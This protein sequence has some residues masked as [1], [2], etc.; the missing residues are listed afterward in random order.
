MTSFLGQLAQMGPQVSQMGTQ[1]G[2]G[3]GRVLSLMQQLVQLNA[4]ATGYDVKAGSTT[5]RYTDNR[6]TFNSTARSIDLTIEAADAVVQLSY[7]GVA[8]APEFYVKAGVIYSLGIACKAMQIR[9][10]LTAT[11]ALYQAMVQA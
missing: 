1:L 7:D 6:L 2:E 3:M 11:P 4:P 5:D 10:R 9:S 8:F